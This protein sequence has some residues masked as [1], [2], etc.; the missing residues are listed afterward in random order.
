[1]RIRLATRL[2]PLLAVL[3][4]FLGLSGTTRAHPEG[5]DDH[6]AH[7][8]ALRSGLLEATKRGYHLYMERRDPQGSYRVFEG[9]L[10]SVKPLLHHHKDLQKKI[11]QALST[12]E[13]NPDMAQ[14][15]LALRKVVDEVSDRLKGKGAKEEV[16]KEEV[17]KEEVKKEEVKKEEV[18]KKE[19]TKKEEVKKKEEPK[20]EEV[21]KEEVKKEEVKK[22]EPKKEEV[23]KEEP[24]KEDK[25]NKKGAKVDL[26]PGT[27]AVNGKVTID[28]QPLSIGF[29]SLVSVQDGRKYGSA[30]YP[31]GTY[32]IKKGIPAG[33]YKVILEQ[34]TST[35]GKNQKV[36]AIPE[37]YQSAETTEL[38][39][40]VNAG[41]N[42]FDITIKK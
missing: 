7:D 34:S 40:T 33:E 36:I 22:E 31:G 10:L 12:A 1:M 21:K 26:P 19:E 24:K 15:A 8:K 29:V 9:A 5:D 23:K 11:D 32:A 2:V 18:K 25:D 13:A 35:P 16:K 42:T 39:V 41:Q 17:K 3:G 37:A 14:R 20:K 30:I 27:G 6:A 4:L 38:T 28:G